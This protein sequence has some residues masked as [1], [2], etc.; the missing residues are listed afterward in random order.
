MR[1]EV[2]VTG[3]WDWS[4]ETVIPAEATMMTPMARRARAA[5]V[6]T[7]AGRMVWFWLASR[8][9]FVAMAEIIGVA[10]VFAWK[11]GVGRMSARVCWRWLCVR[12]W[13]RVWGSGLEA[14]MLGVFGRSGLLVVGA[15]GVALV[16][17]C[18][19]PASGGGER[20]DRVVLRGSVGDVRASVRL[21]VGRSVHV[22]SF[23]RVHDGVRSRVIHK[24]PVSRIGHG[25]GSRYGHGYRHR[26]GHRY[27]GRYGHRSGS[28]GYWGRFS[29]PTTRFVLVDP[30]PGRRS[31]F[32]DGA[33][34]DGGS[35]GYAAWRE[36][37]RV[38]G[39][40]RAERESARESATERAVRLSR[41]EPTVGESAAE[42][43]RGVRRGAWVAGR[44]FEGEGEARVVVG[45]LREGA[46]AALGRGETGLALERFGAVSRSAGVRASDLAGYAAGLAL[47]GRFEGAVIAMRRGML[48]EGGADG[49]RLGSSAGGGGA[50]VE[51]VV[52]A[53]D[54][55]RGLVAERVV[56]GEAGEGERLLAA[57]L[58]ALGGDLAKARRWHGL[59]GEAGEG[60]A[61]WRAF[62]EMLDL[63]EIGGG[64]GVGA[65][66]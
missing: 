37:V 17:V 24:R 66:G 43:A 6:M 21:G 56:M 29:S 8:G 62:G 51:G 15:A 34:R 54:R 18:S 4:G 40:R 42:G 65:G 22:R 39:E 1:M 57:G 53:L 20:V 11:T 59:A 14:L 60:G 63:W 5:R 35:P 38:I 30:G 23:G 52:S 19:S 27:G 31:A 55:V 7:S 44:G 50:G 61:A 32:V 25:V 33:A 36:A 9:V 26:Y 3:L 49:F 28:W 64:G 58:A 46:W 45:S 10:L 48:T 12:S 16:L 41:V 2:M 13:G 47:A